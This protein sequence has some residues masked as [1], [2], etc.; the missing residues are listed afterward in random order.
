MKRQDLENGYATMA[1]EQQQYY[2]DTFR[3]LEDNLIA[4]SKGGSDAHTLARGLAHFDNLPAA[5]LGIRSRRDARYGA[6]PIADSSLADSLANTAA[7]ATAAN[8]MRT[9]LEE[10]NRALKNNMLG[11]GTN[12]QQTTM[13]TMGQLNANA[14]Q[15][16]AAYERYKQQS[17]Q[18][19]AGMLGSGLMAGYGGYMN[20]QF[21]G[22]L[23]GTAAPAASG[24]FMTNPKTGLPY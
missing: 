6:T 8:N 2:K 17:D 1:A 22:L 4:M 23:G 12:M 24:Q 20:G 15:R 9:Q 3:P 5:T 18:A 16:A 11:L 7:Q 14:Q 21:G 19:W 10:E 13:N